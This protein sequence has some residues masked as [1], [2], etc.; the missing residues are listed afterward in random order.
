MMN[1]NFDEHWRADMKN[2]P[3]NSFF[4]IWM[5]FLAIFLIAATAIVIFEMPGISNEFR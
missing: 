2:R 5:V 4:G 3:N 1:H